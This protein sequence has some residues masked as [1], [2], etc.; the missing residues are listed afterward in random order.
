MVES[1][2]DS[3]FSQ[4]FGDADAENPFARQGTPAVPDEPT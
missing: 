4:W 3:V 2:S 1:V